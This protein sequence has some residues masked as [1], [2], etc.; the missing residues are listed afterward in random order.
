MTQKEQ[1]PCKHV[2]EHLA[3]DAPLLL[4][5]VLSIRCIPF[6]C[7]GLSLGRKQRMNIVALQGRTSYGLNNRES[8]SCSSWL[9]LIAA[10]AFAAVVIATSIE[11]LG[12]LAGETSG[13]RGNASRT[14][15][16]TGE[17]ENVWNDDSK[18]RRPCDLMGKSST[19]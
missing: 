19:S 15:D 13:H 7:D 9:S 5:A 18:N 12:W 1:Q 2:P 17:E 14:Q 16:E 3:S 4:L 6:K 11:P 10:A 8:L